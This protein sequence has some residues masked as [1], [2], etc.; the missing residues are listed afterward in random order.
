MGFLID[1]SSFMLIPLQ[2]INSALLE[3]TLDP[4]AMFT[5]GYCDYSEADSIGMGVQQKRDYTITRI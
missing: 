2:A 5:S 1:K 4:Y 3:L